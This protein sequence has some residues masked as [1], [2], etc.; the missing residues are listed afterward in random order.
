MTTC[1]S[2][3]CPVKEVCYRSISDNDNCQARFN[4]EYTCN[5]YT[6]FP[7]YV[8]IKIHEKEKKIE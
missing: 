4:Y 2:I 5:D 3:K 8:S 1:T 6:G 7:D